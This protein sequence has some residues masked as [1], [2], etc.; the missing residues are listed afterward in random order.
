MTGLR[1][2]V[3]GIEHGASCC[4]PLNQFNNMGC[5]AHSGGNY[6]IPTV[7]RAP[8][9]WRHIGAEHSAAPGGL[10]VHAVCRHQTWR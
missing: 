8:A 4:S 10:Y 6:T 2:I 5:C 7:V 9:A 3:E 1:P